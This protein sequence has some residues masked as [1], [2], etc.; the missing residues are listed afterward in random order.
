[1]LRRMSALWP[2]RGAQVV[3][4]DVRRAAGVVQPRGRRHCWRQS[5]EDTYTRKGNYQAAWRL[6]QLLVIGIRNEHG[7]YK[8]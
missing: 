3:D 5:G 7:I 4:G 2:G 6:G 1:M 8:L